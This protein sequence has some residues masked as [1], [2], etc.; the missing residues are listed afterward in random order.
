[1][2]NL[3]GLI[4]R[5]QAIVMAP[6]AEWPVIVSEQATVA[7][8]FRD[9]VLIL[10]AIPAVC[11]FLKYSVIGFGVPFSGTYR[12][13]IG[14]GLGYMVMTYALSLAVVYVTALI[15]DF[16]APTFG[17]QKDPLQAFK[18]VA[19]ASTASWIAGIG[20]LV[21]WVSVLIL[22]AGGVYSIYLL[23]LALPL[24]MKCP[25]DKAVAYTAVVVV[26]AIIFGWIISAVVGSAFL[27]RS[28]VVVPQ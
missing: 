21:P 26:V 17:A 28:G 9:Y 25:A 24:T 12:I 16:L 19:Y 14:S 11:G 22:I 1:M 13:G 15:V 7:S 5:T 3:T 23:Y 10:A 20:Q 18:T 6:R 27:P 2:A 4:A 8:I